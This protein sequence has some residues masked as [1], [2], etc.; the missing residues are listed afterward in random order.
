MVVAVVVVM[1]VVVRVRADALSI[2]TVESR[3]CG[4]GAAINYAE[5]RCDRWRNVHP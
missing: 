1:V 2:G 3:R 5:K 4:G